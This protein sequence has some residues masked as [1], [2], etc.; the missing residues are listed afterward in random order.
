[1]GFMKKGIW[2]REELKG[3]G[4]SHLHL[5]LL[6]FLWVHFYR[7]LQGYCLILEGRGDSYLHFLLLVFLWVHLC[8]GFYT[9]AASFK[10][11]IRLSL[12]YQIR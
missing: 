9:V 1:M 5:F 8:R 4:G 12:E 11:H 2:R 6:V 3:R 10:N 7:G